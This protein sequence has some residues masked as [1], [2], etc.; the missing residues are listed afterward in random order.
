MAGSVFGRWSCGCLLACLVAA[1]CNRPTTEDP[2]PSPSDV[3]A[4]S[5]AQS[6]APAAQSQGAAADHGTPAV[7]MPQEAAPSPAVSQKPPLEAADPT[8]LPQVVMAASDRNACKVFVGDRFPAFD[9]N[10][11]SGQPHS[12]QGSLGSKGTVVVFFQLGDD[13]VSRLRAENLLLDIQSDVASKYA[14]DEIA[15]LAIHAGEA[16]SGLSELLQ[17]AEVTFPVLVDADETVFAQLTTKRPPCLY[18][19][20]GQGKV[21]W[22][23]IEYGPAVRQQLRQAVRA[24]A[25]N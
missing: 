4:R 7:A 6:Q 8:V 3:V 15:V 23:D 24:L 20:D 2:K 17:G 22:L 13:A 16:P 12:A 1:G 25:E 19:L 10:D 18:V 14:A 21:A 9:L 5:G 11:L